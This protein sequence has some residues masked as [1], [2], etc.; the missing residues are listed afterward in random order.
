M[1]MIRTIAA[2][3]TLVAVTG[4]AQGCRCTGGDAPSGGAAPPASAARVAS[5]PPADRLFATRLAPGSPDAILGASRGEL[6]VAEPT[7]T[8]YAIRFRLLGPGVAELVAA[9]DAG[10]GY[11]L[12][13]AWGA[14]KH[15]GASP[16]VLQ[17]VD[18]T[19]GAV[20]ELFRRSGERNGA[21][22]LS[23]SDVD[24]DG[25][26]D[27]AFAYFSTKRDVR[28]R[29]VTASGRV[30]EGDP[31]STAQARAF[32]D[33]DGD[34][35]ADEIVGRLYGDVGTAPGDLRVD[36]GRGW[37][38]V[39]TEGGVRAVA[40]I[41]V[42]GSPALLFA[43]GWF[44]NYGKQ[45]RARLRRARW[46]GAG[47]DVETLGTSPGEFTFFDIA[48][49]PGSKSAGALVVS[50]DKRITLFR[51]ASMPPW[52]SEVLAEGERGGAAVV[53]DANDGWTVAVPGASPNVLP[54]RF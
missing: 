48:V 37:I 35:S 25:R 2:I 49:L 10:R 39:P 13:L 4:A 44:A 22:H 52:P 17:E 33:L 36:L 53:R 7:A 1:P 31:M 46:N 19:T 42:S 43:D 5:L 32:G 14:P 23:V 41:N 54:I 12:Y 51:P 27:L 34:G 38:S 11:R 6:W 16:L 9:G 8:G 28:T 18:P 3:A 15:D 40:V 45:G 30:I 21:A 47:F 50:G 26:P 20:V 29:H 24:R